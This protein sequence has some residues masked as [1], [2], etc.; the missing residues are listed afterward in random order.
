MCSCDRVDKTTRPAWELKLLS[1]SWFNSRLSGLAYFSENICEHLGFV[2]V[3][4]AIA[5]P[6]LHA[7]IQFPLPNPLNATFF[8]DS[9][10][11]NTS[12]WGGGWSCSDG[13]REL[14][15]S[16]VSF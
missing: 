14:V 16:R 11:L 12:P 6:L 7:E 15:Q 4:N 10:R 13:E 3:N 2:L 5:S 9:F 8:R 1:M